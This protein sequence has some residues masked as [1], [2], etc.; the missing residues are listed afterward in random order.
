M[1][2]MAV[3]YQVSAWVVMTSGLCSLL[4]GPRFLNIP[5]RWK[6]GNVPVF[7]MSIQNL[8]VSN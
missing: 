7:T 1:E 8:Q 4:S 3:N 5:V 2:T 6:N